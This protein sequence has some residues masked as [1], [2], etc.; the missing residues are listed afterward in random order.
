MWIN[1]IS[2][3]YKAQQLYDLLSF[4]I[5]AELFPQLIVHLGQNKKV[6]LRNSSN[7]DRS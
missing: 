5:V 4:L 2:Y 3:L 7:L 6:L 1:Y